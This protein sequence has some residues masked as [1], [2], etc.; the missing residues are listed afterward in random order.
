MEIVRV[1]GEQGRALRAAQ[2][3]V[4]HKLLLWLAAEDTE[5]ETGE[6]MGSGGRGPV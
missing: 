5:R 1:S 3:Q 2:A 4:I 6:R